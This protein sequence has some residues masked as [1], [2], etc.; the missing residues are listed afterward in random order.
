M[1]LN[2]KLAK[3][4]SS[5]KQAGEAEGNGGSGVQNKPVSYAEESDIFSAVTITLNLPDGSKKS[6]NGT[7]GDTIQIIKKRL[8]AEIGLPYHETSC[9]LPDGTLMI[10]PLSLNDFPSLDKTNPV[11]EV[12]VGSVIFFS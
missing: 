12:R 3:V 2:L 11:I 4:P 7:T 10:E 8:E 5:D 1:K 6:F 9:H